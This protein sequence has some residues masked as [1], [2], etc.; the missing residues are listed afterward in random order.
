MQPYTQRLKKGTKFVNNKFH[1]FLI[2]GDQNTFFCV[3][4]CLF[5]RLSV[6]QRIM[7]QY[8]MVSCSYPCTNNTISHKIQLMHTCFYATLLTLCHSDIF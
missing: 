8:V 4:M 6:Q 2:P 3:C 7:P 5:D 1:I